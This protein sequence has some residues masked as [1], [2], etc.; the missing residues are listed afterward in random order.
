MPPEVRQTK[1][2]YDSLPTASVE[3][4]LPKLIS[5]G[6]KKSFW[7]HSHLPISCISQGRLLWHMLWGAWLGF[8]LFLL[9]LPRDIAKEST[10]FQLSVGSS[11]RMQSRSTDLMK[12]FWPIKSLAIL[13]W[14]KS[15]IQHTSCFP[16]DWTWTKVGRYLCSFPVDGINAHLPLSLKLTTHPVSC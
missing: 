11:S 16:P 4:F 13:D 1:S 10:T 2:V 8:L 7:S 12:T 14:K 5:P 3:L 9:F 15:P 6:M